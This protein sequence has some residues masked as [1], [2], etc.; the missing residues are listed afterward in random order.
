MINDRTINEAYIGLKTIFGGVREDYFGLLYLEQE[1]KVPREKA[2]NQIAFGGNDYG[3]DGF[4]FDE[5][6]RNLYLFQFKYTRAHAQFKGT[7]QRL[8]DN[9]VERVFLAPNK[10]DHKNQ[11]LIQ[12]RSCLQENRAIID[13]VC[14]RFVFIGDPEE[15]ERSQAL[16]K[17][18]EDLEEKSGLLNVFFGREVQMVVDFRSSTGRVV[19]LST[20]RK[21]TTFSV[22][23]QKKID[24]TG[25]EGQTMYLGFIRLTDLHG[26]HLALGSH[27]FDRNIRYGLG[28]SETVNRALSHALRQIVIDGND[29]PRVFT[30]NHNGITLYAE[31]VDCNEGLCRITSPRLLN[32][33]QTVTTVKAFLESFQLDPRLNEQHGRLDDVQV[34]C[35]IITGANAKFITAVTINN[36][37]QTPVEPWSL[38]ANDFIQLEL[39]DKLRDDLGVYYERQENA[40]D[41]LSTEDL[42]E[43][44]ISEESK[45][46]QMLKLTQ[47]F[48]LTDGAISRI[49]EMRRVFE[50][51]KVYDQVFRSTRLRTDSRHILLCYKAQFRLR[52]LSREIEQKGQNKYW[53]ISRARYLLWALLCQGLLNHRELENLSEEYGT[54]MS[55]PAGYTELLTQIATT[56]VRPMLSALMNDPDYADKVAEDNLSFLRTDRAFD[57]CM[58]IAANKWGWSHKKLA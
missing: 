35:K 25:P 40:F 38:H 46:V 41:Q 6:R 16:G 42:E 58:A 1:H 11:I 14:F 49:S 32:G 28:D 54:T 33:A 34:L 22:R 39:Q 47:T 31:K 52:K 50:D 36:N 20:P 15:A 56:K 48:L 4:H 44:G 53:F 2:L 19:T 57:K 45:A 8:I 29:D 9:G 3:I 26:I 23:F 13:Q 43:Y 5:E 55:L 37:R 27:F 30:F 18:R 12:L 7:L 51:D 24:F 10:D 17:L 21:N